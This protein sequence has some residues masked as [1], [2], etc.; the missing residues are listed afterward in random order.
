MNV[1]AWSCA[2]SFGAV[3]IGLL[4][5]PVAPAASSEFD[6][7]M[8]SAMARMDTAMAAAPM[9]G[10]ADHDFAGMMIPHHQGAV[11]M[12]KEELVQGR[13]PRLRRLAQEIIVTQLSEIQVMQMAQRDPLPAKESR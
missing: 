9:N 2:A 7:E 4:S 8:M 3:V 10:N 11:D 5:L 12:A 1:C 13:D 6:R